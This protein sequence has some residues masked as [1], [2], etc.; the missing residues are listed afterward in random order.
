MFYQLAKFG[1]VGMHFLNAPTRKAKRHG[2]EL[3]LRAL[4]TIE[5]PEKD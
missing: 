3:A 2:T 1:R 5:S 4:N